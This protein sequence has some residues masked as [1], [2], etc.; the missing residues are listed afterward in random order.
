[1]QLIYFAS[2]VLQ[3]SRQMHLYGLLLGLAVMVMVDLAERGRMARAVMR[4][5]VAAIVALAT[6]ALGLFVVAIARYNGHPAL[7]DTL[8]AAVASISWESNAHHFIYDRDPTT[9]VVAIAYGPVGFRLYGLAQAITGSV[10][11]APKALAAGGA[12]VGIALLAVAAVR[13]AGVLVGGIIATLVATTIASGGP[14]FAMVLTDPLLLLGAGIA[15]ALIAASRRRGVAAVAFAVCS[16]VAMIKPHVGLAIWT[17]ALVLYAGRV[18]MR[19]AIVTACVGAAAG[20]AL[21]FLLMPAE[22]MGFVKILLT[23]G[24]QNRIPSTTLWDNIALVGIPLL[25]CA[26]MELRLRAG[27]GWMRWIGLLPLGGLAAATY[28]GSVGVND[29]TGILVICLC[30]VWS[31]DLWRRGGEASRLY[32][33]RA[34]V[35][36]AAGLLPMF[37]GRGPSMLW[38][39]RGDKQESARWIAEGQAMIATF[40]GRVAVGIGDNAQGGW[41]ARIHAPHMFAAGAS[42][43]IEFEALTIWRYLGEPS[44]DY[45]PLLTSAAVDGWLLPAR[46]HPFELSSMYPNAPPLIEPPERAAFTREFQLVCEGAKWGLWM[47]RARTIPDLREKCARAGGVVP[48]PPPSPALPPA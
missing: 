29:N 43:L 6:V 38:Q 13:T 31:A 42:N 16:A 47:H 21:V 3:A 14:Y 4:A 41:W 33:R 39:T 24:K 18:P 5:Q 11:M 30:L 9:R 2:A 15:L 45:R 1:M 37:I 36:L 28:V 22:S 10:I 20:F 34:S 19:E 27:D 12:L 32:L 46:A 48:I 35:L 25:I 40:G 8:E 7:L 17:V 44:A 23:N 26:A